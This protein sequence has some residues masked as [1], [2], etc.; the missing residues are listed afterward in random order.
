MTL[1]EYVKKIPGHRNSKGE[2]APWAIVSHKTGKVLSSH[3]TKAEAEEHLKQMHIF[4]E[5]MEMERRR[6][7]NRYS[8]EY[9]KMPITLSTVV[10]IVGDDGDVYADN[11]KNPNGTFITVKELIEDYIESNESGEWTREELEDFFWNIPAKEALEFIEDGWGLAIEFDMDESRQRRGHMLHEWRTLGIF[12]ARDNEKIKEERGRKFLNALKEL[13]LHAGYKFEPDE[14]SWRVDGLDGTTLR[15]PCDLRDK[16]TK[17]L[18]DEL[19]LHSWI[20]SWNWDM[21]WVTAEK[22]IDD[23]YFKSLMDLLSEFL[24]SKGVKESR[25]PRGRM[26]KESGSDGFLKKHGFTP[27][28]EFT[29]GDYSCDVCQAPISEWQYD[30]FDGLCRECASRSE[31]KRVEIEDWP[32]MNEGKDGSDTEV[33][34]AFWTQGIWEDLVNDDN[35]ETNP[36]G[37]YTHWYD[38]EPTPDEHRWYEKAENVVCRWIKKNPGKNSLDFEKTSEY[39]KIRSE[40][41]EILGKKVEI[42]EGVVPEE[43]FPRFDKI[44]K[45][46]EH[47]TGVIF[48]EADAEDCRTVGDVRYAFSAPI[49]DDLCLYLALFGDGG[50]GCAVI[51]EPGTKPLCREWSC[52]VPEMIE[53]GSKMVEEYGEF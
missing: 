20:H 24:R 3:K 40:L 30:H 52:S 8:D 28:E 14:A 45:G 33:K 47:R 22:F 23:D 51:G 2:P 17:E 18:F 49:S 41:E 48:S 7:L 5:G 36:S 26:L 31:S 1:L 27:A 6:V 4:K 21:I 29:D 46:I 32:K 9:K 35:P 13:C 42:T 15:I 39:G 44:Y 11:F 50:F 19:R 38:V 10:H 12:P 53:I 16:K 34:A 37:E 43:D 25:K